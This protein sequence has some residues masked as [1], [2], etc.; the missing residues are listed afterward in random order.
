MITAEYIIL[1]TGRELIGRILGENIYRATEFDILPLNPDVSVQNSPNAVEAHLLHLVRSHLEGGLFL[2]SY[3]W[4]LTRRLQAQ[5][6]GLEN[7][8]DKVLWEVVR[9]LLVVR[10]HTLK[11]T[12]RQTIGSFG[13]SAL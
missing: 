7:D 13:T 3:S 5:W 4:D 9:I 12:L 2:L 11:N 8:R 1:L 10:A 6:A